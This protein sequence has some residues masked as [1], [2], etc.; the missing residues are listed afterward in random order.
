MVVPKI[1][2]WVELQCRGKKKK[3]G[4]NIFPYKGEEKRGKHIRGTYR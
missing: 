3:R 2:L 1:S 4:E